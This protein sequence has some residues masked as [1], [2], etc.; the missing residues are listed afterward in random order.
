[1]SEIL[2]KTNMSTSSTTTTTTAPT[3]VA[4][5]IK[6][7]INNTMSTG[8][9]TNK[10][11]NATT[12]NCTGNTAIPAPVA[13]P[14]GIPITPSMAA[15]GVTSNGVAPFAESSKALSAGGSNCSDT[16]SSKSEVTSNNL[17]N[18]KEKT[19]MCLINEL[20]RFNKVQHQYV[21]TDEQGPA[22]KKVFFVKLLLGD[23]EEYFASGPSIKKAQHIAAAQA[24]EKTQFK[25]PPP[26]QT[27]TSITAKSV[28]ATVELNAIA[29]K[30]GELAEYRPMEMHQPQF[31]PPPSLDFRG[32]YNQRYHYPRFPRMYYVSL[33][34]GQR[35][36]I[37]QGT[38]RQG[39]RHNAAEKAI[40]VLRGLPVTPEKKPETKPAS[41]T[42]TETVEENS[43]DVIKSE[44]SLVHEI[45]LKRNMNVDFKVVHE[46]GPPHMRQF[47]TSCRCGS[48]ETQGE[49]NSKKLSKKRAAISM[50][51]E[52]RRLT[53]LPPSVMNRPK[54][55]LPTKKKQRNIVKLQKAAPDYGVGI[56]PISRLIQIQQAKKEREPVYSLVMEQ[57][58]PRHREF[59]MEVSVGDRSCNGVGPN[60]KLAK[61]SAAESML[62]HLGYS[63][64]VP[65]PSKP[66]IKTSAAAADATSVT[67]SGD[68]K[69]TFFDTEGNS[70]SRQL[71]PGLILMPEGA[72]LM[73]N[74][75]TSESGVSN[76]TQP[77]TPLTH[78]AGGTS[79]ANPLNRAPGAPLQAMSG[80]G[81]K[82]VGMQTVMA[83]AKE[84]LETGFSPTAESLR[85]KSD[86][87]LHDMKL[88][89]PKQQ[90]LY[91]ADILG[92][93]V[94][95]TDLPKGCNKSDYTSLVSLL[96]SPQRLSHG[97]GPTVEASHD[98]ASHAALKSLAEG[99]L[100]DK[101]PDNMG[102]GDGPHVKTEVG[103]TG[104]K[105]AS[106]EIGTHC[107]VAVT[108]APD[109]VASN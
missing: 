5:S 16:S 7:V 73:N 47:V 88:V 106:S 17:A 79:P 6:P 109:P 46:S 100:R 3:Q 23:T 28:T 82:L 52:L 35:E 27:K 101:V 77:Y 68:K 20:A 34:V 90:L 108:T 76:M 93:Q 104:E 36:F 12:N 19:P 107:G 32:M 91:L 81:E 33:K 21:L 43:D 65:Q 10:L 87:G 59:V 18:T 38:C 78:H 60:K 1:M 61:R 4:T 75:S 105:R 31:Y 41:A 39:A 72:R 83:I 102:A 11:N 24:L 66:A 25:H 97:S 15:A 92:V 45:A 86:N 58:L 29:M 9:G 40:H 89:R 49:G 71:A 26:K 8:S 103:G 70:S 96:M 44:I 51:E 62:Q 64:P 50:L 80:G 42:E 67:N 53:P 94:Q 57:G 95:F 2:K 37:G 22:H 13:M 55:A 69:V 14:N 54:K 84:L 99:G 30:R 48:F 56:N 63:R 74:T 85:G 98:M